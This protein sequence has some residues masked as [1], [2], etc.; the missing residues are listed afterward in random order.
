LTATMITT[1]RLTMS[2]KYVVIDRHAVEE[3]RREDGEIVSLT[4]PV[5]DGPFD[6]PHEADFATRD[7]RGYEFVEIEDE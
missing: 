6:D 4:L 3:V 1:E 2:R 5:V 7:N